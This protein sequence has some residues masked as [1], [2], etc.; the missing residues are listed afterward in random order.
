M[1]P[2][3]HKSG[4]G[5]RKW[6]GNRLGQLRRK[7]HPRSRS[8][9]G[10]CLSEEDTRARPLPWPPQPRPPKGEAVHCRR[11][12]RAAQEAAPSA[13]RGVALLPARRSAGRAVSALASRPRE[14][15]LASA[16]RRVPPPLLGRGP[17]ASWPPFGAKLLGSLL[18]GLS[19]AS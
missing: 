9:P 14:S 13:W 7:Y 12:T 17:E 2:A 1:P 19:G 8:V 4:G 16:M 3:R 18:G 15:L 11:R 10:A 6:G 5:C